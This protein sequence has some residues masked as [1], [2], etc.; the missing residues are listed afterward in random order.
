[1]RRTSRRSAA[2]ALAAVVSLTAAACSGGEDPVEDDGPIG[3]LAELSIMAPQAAEVDLATNKF[4]K[5]MEEKFNIKFTW[6]PTAV[7]KGPATEKRQIALAS[8]DYPDVFMLVSYIDYIQRP[9][10]LKLGE[11]GV[12]V[13]LQD[14]IK[15]YAPN[16][17]A[18]LDNN[19]EYRALVT[20]PD[21]NI[22]GLAQIN[23]CYH[24]SFPSKLW[25]NSA[26]LDKLGLEQ[27]T[28]TD[29]LREVLRA[30]KTRDPN[31]NGKADEVPLTANSR[32]YLVPYFMNAF[33][34][35]ATGAESSKPMAVLNNG[36]VELPATRE[37]WREGLRFL[38][39][40]YA[41]GLIDQGAFTQTP[42]AELKIG[43]NPDAE[44]IGASTNL[45]P[46]IF[47]S[48]GA[49]DERDKHYDAVPPLTGPGGVSYASYTS[50]AHP[51]AAFVLTN[52]ATKNDRVAAIKMLD[53][54]FTEEG[55][56]RSTYGE[57]GIDWSRPEA[58]DV[59]L[60]ETVDPIWK[61]LP[62]E[63]DE[64][65]NRTWGTFTGY[66]LTREFRDAQAV[67]E[68]KYDALGYERRLYEATQLYEPKLPK[69]VVFPYWK[70][71]NDPAE[72]SEYASLE[73]NLQ[74]YVKENSLGFITGSKNLDTDWDAY[75]AGFEGM[76]LPRYLELQQKYYD[77]SPK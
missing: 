18:E 50:P 19:P 38:Q 56:L 10:L 52:K 36:R 48:S 17:Q 30:F 51:G 53:H 37:E 39:S 2:L 28:T 42:E 43:D 70:V 34:Y 68:D 63:E 59:A 16:I 6:Q 47:V 11:Q 21:G 31:G 61:P 26:W 75:V 14:L 55:T 29:E 4:S 8:G 57:E 66:Y 71:W 22:Y 40:L 41:E 1:M 77:A 62:S 64:E 54:F 72:A 15:E 33:T 24:C 5:E 25:M 69:D 32:D 58:G 46:Y 67:P 13:P 49:D 20:A 23:D 45:H 35:D 9:E 60:N 76:Q 74:S 73:T 27:P 65:P 44:L 12:A 3:G 7:D